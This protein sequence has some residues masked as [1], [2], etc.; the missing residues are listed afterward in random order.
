MSFDLYFCPEGGATPSLSE[1]KEYFASLPL[2]E[3]TDVEDDGAE[4]WY[5]NEVTGV[6]CV[7]S[8]SSAEV[9]E[10]EECRSGGVSFSLN[11][12]RPSFFAFES[13][14]LVESFCTRF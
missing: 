11:S 13:I 3:V 2:F 1:L 4:F 7:F 9:D 5:E 8:Y 10:L 12:C 14:P 6:Y